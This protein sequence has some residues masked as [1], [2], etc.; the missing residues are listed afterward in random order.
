VLCRQFSFASGGIC[1]A[2][3]EPRRRNRSQHEAAEALIQAAE[4]F[5]DL[6]SN[7]GRMEKTWVFG[8]PGPR[9]NITTGFAAEP[10]KM[11]LPSTRKFQA[12]HHFRWQ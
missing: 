5:D 11:R 3:I 12:G 2:E 4:K 9:Q 10:G 6:R 1:S 8:R 7:F